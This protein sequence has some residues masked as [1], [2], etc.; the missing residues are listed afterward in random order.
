M[1]GRARK[2]PQEHLLECV[3]EDD[4]IRPVREAKPHSADKLTIL[5]AYLPALRRASRKAPRG[6]FVDALAGPGLYH[7]SS[8]GRATGT[9]VEGKFVKGSTLIAR[10][11]NPP[12]DRVFAMDID[13]KNVE[14]LQQRTGGDARIVVR[15]G[16][17]NQDLLPL[18]EAELA[19]RRAPVFV[20]VDPEGFEVKWSTI[21]R[22]SRFRQGPKKT[23][24][25]I[26]FA[27]PSLA[28]FTLKGVQAFTMNV[29]E[30]MPPGMAWRSLLLQAKGSGASGKEIAE[31]MVERYAGALRKDLGYR[32][33]AARPIGPSGPEDRGGRVFYYLVYATDFVP[34]SNEG[35]MDWIFANLWGSSSSQPKLF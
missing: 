29:D 2:S 18:L 12:F 28:R 32:H 33:V 14:A 20:F 19:D 8:G 6:Y 34:T 1:A 22:L 9:L 35:P 23:E 16:D 4:G 7:F 30:A 24:L 31:K 3:V 5:A 21:E 15:K 10:D 17:C 11:T 27:A 25:L 13:A 26:Y